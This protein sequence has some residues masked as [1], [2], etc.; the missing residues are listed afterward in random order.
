MEVKQHLFSI[1][2]FD[3]DCITGGIESFFIYFFDISKWYIEIIKVFVLECLCTHVV[4]VFSFMWRMKDYEA[5]FLYAYVALNNCQNVNKDAIT[6]EL[7]YLDLL[8]FLFRRVLYAR[9]SLS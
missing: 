4:K 2:G 1:L 6:L 7:F 9:L 8:A 5:L 3:I